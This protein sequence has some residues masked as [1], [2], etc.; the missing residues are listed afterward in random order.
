MCAACMQ[1]AYSST[2]PGMHPSCRR[3]T[4]IPF[5]DPSQVAGNE[6]DNR[7]GRTA[8]NYPPLDYVDERTSGPHVDEPAT[9]DVARPNLP[10]IRSQHPTGGTVVGTSHKPGSKGN[11]GHQTKSRRKE[12]TH[13][14]ERRDSDGSGMHT[15]DVEV[16]RPNYHSSIGAL[17]LPSDTRRRD[18]PGWR[19]ERHRNLGHRKRTRHRRVRGRR[20]PW[21]L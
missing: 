9:M 6:F 4:A 5:S 16:A 17:G 3:H 13:S 2:G 7:P 8:L 10:T 1:I 18:K 20:D 19:E 12:T 21:R 15:R 11:P 14:T